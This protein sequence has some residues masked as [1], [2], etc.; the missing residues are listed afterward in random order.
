MTMTEFANEINHLLGTTTC[1]GATV[2]SW[3]RAISLPN[4]ERLKVIDQLGNITLKELLG[5]DLL[6][7]I[8]ELEATP[9]KERFPEK[10][11]CCLGFLMMRASIIIFAM[12]VIYGELMMIMK[13]HN[14]LN[15]N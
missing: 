15:Q 6:N 8:A 1:S 7:L 3:E 2:S 10:S 12:T 13:I 5:D 11:L 9:I 14:L 4:S